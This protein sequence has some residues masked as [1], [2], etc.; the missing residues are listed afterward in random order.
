MTYKVLWSSTTEMQRNNTA[1]IHFTF[2]GWQK[3]KCKVLRRNSEHRSPCR[4][5]PVLHLSATQS[6]NS[7]AS[8]IVSY[9]PEYLRTGLLYF[10]RSFPCQLFAFE[11]V[12]MW[13][14][15]QQ[16]PGKE[17]HYASVPKIT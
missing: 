13:E 5:S 9:L 2:W 15:V 10:V 3:R 7:I 6:C 14:C 17:H 16:K 1:Q 12:R 8:H 4:V 11:S